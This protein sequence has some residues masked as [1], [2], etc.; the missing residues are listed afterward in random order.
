MYYPGKAF[1]RKIYNEIGAAWKGNR[2]DP[3]ED[4]DLSEKRAPNDEEFNKR[5]DH[6]YANGLLCKV[7]LWVGGSNVYPNNP[8]IGLEVIPL[9][10]PV[11]NAPATHIG[12]WHISIAFHE[13][14][15]TDLERAFIEKY[16]KPQTLRLIF[17][18][19]S[20]W[21]AVSE[22]DVNNDPIASDPVAQALHQASYYRDA[23]LHITF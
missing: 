3:P 9:E 20:R 6:I 12:T 4:T 21:N 22:L 15:N 11:T 8:L 10:T 23:A 2:P 18:N 17:W 19:I 14:Y 1:D 7:R 13:H 5:R 16:N